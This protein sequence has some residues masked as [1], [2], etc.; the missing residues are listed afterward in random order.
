MIHFPCTVNGIFYE[1][2]RIAFRAVFLPKN[3]S[4]D[5]LQRALKRGFPELEGIRIE[6]VKQRYA[7]S[8]PED[9][10]DCADLLPLPVKTAPSKERKTGEPLLRYPPGESPIEKG[11]S[12][13]Y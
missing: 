10:S 6:R 13:C 9:D 5:R 1:N 2:T 3:I 4:Y 12:R 11:L 7:L 8:P